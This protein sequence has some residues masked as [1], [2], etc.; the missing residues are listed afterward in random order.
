MFHQTRRMLFMAE[1]HAAANPF[2]CC[3]LRLLRKLREAPGQTLSH[4]TL[5][6]KMKLDA[7][8]FQQI[9]ETLHQQ[10]DIESSQSLTHGRTGVLYRLTSG[11]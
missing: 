9:I 7:K 1:C 4:S 10:G 5:L 6:K 11:G 8:T 2:H 3:C